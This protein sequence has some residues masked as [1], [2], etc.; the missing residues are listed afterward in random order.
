MKVT[1]KDLDKAEA[2]YEAWDAAA[3]EAYN[4]K[5]CDANAA[6]KAA[7]KAAAYAATAAWNKYVQLKE[8]YE[9][10]SN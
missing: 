7:A 5:A 8:A 10:E 1:K 3:Y 4:A 6:A 9:N 2:A